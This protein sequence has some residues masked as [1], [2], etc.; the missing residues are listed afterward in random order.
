MLGIYNLHILI[1]ISINHG[2]A[3]Y[4][5]CRLASL[6]PKS[7]QFD[8][9]THVSLGDV[10]KFVLDPETRQIKHLICAH[11]RTWL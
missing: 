5:Y 1:H 4:S 3:L 7:L 9:I 8:A 10:I 11:L 6:A 2:K